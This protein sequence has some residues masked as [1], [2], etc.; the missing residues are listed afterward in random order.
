MDKQEDI[1]TNSIP[2]EGDSNYL[3][4]KNTEETVEVNHIQ[5]TRRDFLK[6]AA[7]A[8][9]G[10]GAGSIIGNILTK[11]EVVQTPEV[12]LTPE[13]I[14]EIPV[15]GLTEP[16]TSFEQVKKF[17]KSIDETPKMS[18]DEKY[19]KRKE[20]LDPKE[21]YL[22]IAVL[23]SA[24]DSFSKRKSETGVDFVEW[25]KMTTDIMNVSF[26][27]AKPSSDIRAVLK[28]V[29]VIPDNLANEVW[30][31]NAFSNG[32]GCNFDFTWLCKTKDLLPL[33]TDSSW[34]ISLDYRVDTKNN[35]SNIGYG[36]AFWSCTN[37]NNCFSFE[38]PPGGANKERVIKYPIQNNSLMNSSSTWL[39]C[40]QSHELLHY[41]FNLPDEYGFDLHINNIPK[42]I[43]TTG[44]FHEP[45]VSPYLSLLSKHHIDKKL[46]DFERE[47]YGNG[48]SFHDIPSNITICS[49]E[50]AEVKDIK[51]VRIS[52]KNDEKNVEETPSAF[53]VDK[54]IKVSKEKLVS[55]REYILQLNYL[56]QNRN[57][58]GLFVPYMPF[59]MSK[60]SGLDNPQFQIIPFGDGVYNCEFEQ[61]MYV[62]DESDVNTKMEEVRKLYSIKPFAA[63]KITGTNAWCIWTQ[64][65]I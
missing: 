6:K 55:D 26:A 61:L 12:V 40:G 48:Y 15:Y 37:E 5:M 28:R 35:T 65:F 58:I 46:R 36:G 60:M 1:Q 56:D 52:P 38:F 7:M 9:L 53:A 23:K 27:N 63:M 17:Y 16:I 3:P 31:K 42:L 11:S 29:L 45:W 57:H 21:R 30:D 4:Q 59:T 54:M 8:V 20:L 64:R 41:L 13:I 19:L 47:G 44:S 22:E 39:D 34:G 50:N 24:Y 33:N 25:M 2:E 18:S 14:H 43:V 51:V 62:L 32:D 10:Y 49:S